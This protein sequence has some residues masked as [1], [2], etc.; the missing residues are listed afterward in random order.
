MKMYLHF[1][2]IYFPVYWIQLAKAD[3]RW[4]SVLVS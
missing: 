4:G 3:Y 1:A 2:F